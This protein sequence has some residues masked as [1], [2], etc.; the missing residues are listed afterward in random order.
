[1]AEP[2]GLVLGTL[3]LASLFTDCI[4][5]IQYFELGRNQSHDYETSCLKLSLLRCRLDALG[6]ALNMCRGKQEDEV[7]VQRRANERDVIR[8]SLLG[9][10]NIFGS[11]DIL[12]LKYQLEPRTSRSLTLFSASQNEVAKPASPP[13]HRSAAFRRV[14]LI[15]R[16]T[17]WAIRDKQKFDTLLA[18]LSFFIE[19]L[20]KVIPAV[21]GMPRT[22]SK[23]KTKSKREE[24]ADMMD[25][26]MIS[27]PELVQQK[28]SKS[29]DNKTSVLTLQPTTGSMGTSKKHSL[30]TQRP[31]QRT[32]LML[33]NQPPQ[34]DTVDVETTYS[35]TN[36]G[37]SRNIGGKQFTIQKFEKQSKGALGTFGGAVVAEVPKGQTDMYGVGT[38]TGNA[39]LAAGDH[40]LEAMKLFW[41]ND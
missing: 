20:E 24:K 28:R 6:E 2:V 37:L 5:L 21:Y 35:K 22:Q 4:E 9:I 19:N 29:G 15:R 26:D 17:T 33:R 18:D 1:M 7:I 13:Q 41:A 31:E 3:A 27:E 16:S 8:K 39:R 32:E 30:P 12:T 34:A 23:T 38:V 11:T 10:K 14:S 40:S 36:E 25:L